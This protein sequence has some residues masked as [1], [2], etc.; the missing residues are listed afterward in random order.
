LVE[1][2]REDRVL[3]GYPWTGGREGYG[4][5]E[6]S[7][8]HHDLIR[9]ENER[10]G[11]GASPGDGWVLAVFGVMVDVVLSRFTC[12]RDG[13]GGATGERRWLLRGRGRRRRE[14]AEGRGG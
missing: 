7:V 9:G 8:F 4:H 6:T 10:K 2:E 3:G 1:I 14:G 11:E 13:T 5:G 12:G